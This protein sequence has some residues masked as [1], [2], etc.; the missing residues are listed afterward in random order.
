MTATTD[1]RSA[2]TGKEGSTVTLTIRRSDGQVRDF[3][4]AEGPRRGYRNGKSGRI[5]GISIIFD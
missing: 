5:F 3:M 2:V 4:Q 1:V